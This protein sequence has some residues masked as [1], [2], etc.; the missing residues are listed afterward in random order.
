MFAQALDERTHGLDVS[1]RI[2]VEDDHIFGVGRHQ[3]QS[4]LYDLV[5]NLGDTPG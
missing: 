2:A 4:L 5:E 1:S 3:F